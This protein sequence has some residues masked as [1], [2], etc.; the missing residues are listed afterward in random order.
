[1]KKLTNLTYSKAEK[2]LLKAGFKFVQ[3]LGSHRIFKK[4][5][6]K[7]TL[8]YNSKN[9]FIHPAIANELYNLGNVN[10]PRLKE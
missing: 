4:G 8:L 5:N 9:K 2:I 6:Q 10:N 3:T 7:F 1:L